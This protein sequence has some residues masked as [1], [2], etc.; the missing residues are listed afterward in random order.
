MQTTAINTYANSMF[1]HETMPEAWLNQCT[2]YLQFLFGESLRGATVV[3]YAFGRGNWSVAFLRAG[4]KKV[5]AIDAAEDNVK[6]FTEYCKTYGLTSIEVIHGNLLTDTF[7]PFEADLIWVYG[8][9]H[10]LGTPGVFLDALHPHLAPNGQVYVYAYNAPSLRSVLVNAARKV[11]V[12]SSEEAFAELSPLLIR[13]ARMRLR[14]DWVAP[15][16]D[17]YTPSQLETLLTTHGFYPCRQAD[18]DFQ[19]FLTGQ[20]PWDFYPL[21]VLCRP[22]ARDAVPVTAVAP[23]EDLLSNLNGVEHLVYALLESTPL[24]A[25]KRAFIIGLMNTYYA[26]VGKAEALQTLVELVLYSVHHL[27]AHA[28]A[29]PTVEAWC[30]LVMAAAEDTPRDHFVQTLGMSPLV[31]YFVHNRVRI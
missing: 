19:T 8:I 26:N 24:Q 13:P 15:V 27:R 9:L 1:R 25:Q 16:V 31:A 23:P 30:S 17:F 2:Q 18:S 28:T 3:D 22:N 6:R 11:Q 21:Q 20:A 5:I 29:D 12:I 7:T 4:A 14:D 10:H